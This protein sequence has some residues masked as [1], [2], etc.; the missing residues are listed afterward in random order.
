MQIT[1]G[2]RIRLEDEGQGWFPPYIEPA[3]S[4]TVITVFLD[5]SKR[6]WCVVAFDEV[7]QLQ[8]GGAPTPSGFGQFRYR[9]AVIRPRGLGRN[10]S[11]EGESCFV[12]LVPEGEHPPA[13][14]EDLGESPI[15]IWA[16]CSIINSAAG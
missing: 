16:R 9:W 15:D 11:S 10:L 5:D 4:G 2:S 7:L 14:I 3:L 8:R 12:S 1:R 6:D 13:K